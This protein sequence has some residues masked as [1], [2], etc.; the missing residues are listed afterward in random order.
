MVGSPE[1]NLDETAVRLA[2]GQNALRGLAGD[3]SYVETQQ[4][5]RACLR[6]GS[7]LS[8]RSNLGLTPKLERNPWPSSWAIYGQLGIIQYQLYIVNLKCH[9]M[10]RGAARN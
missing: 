6:L 10:N 5:Q 2:V 7:L 4:H 1:K 8:A 9:R 3:L